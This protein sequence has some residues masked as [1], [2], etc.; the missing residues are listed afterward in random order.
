MSQVV[1]EKPIINS[2]FAEPR[3]HFRFTDEGITNEVL[4][5]RRTSSYFIPIAR[6]RKKGRK[7]LEFDSE[8][9]QDRISRLQPTPRLPPALAGG[10]EQISCRGSRF[11]AGFPSMMLVCCLKT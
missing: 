4:D 6:P 10:D 1:I 2:P 11:P 3:R 7:Q 9:T 8:W 5:G